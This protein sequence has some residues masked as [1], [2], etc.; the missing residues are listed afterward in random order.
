MDRRVK[1]AKHVR[2]QRGRK[3][4]CPRHRA[5]SGSGRQIGSCHPE[6][7]CCSHPWGCSH[8]EAA[9]YGHQCWSKFSGIRYKRLVPVL[10]FAIL[11]EAART[12]V[13]E[14][15]A[16]FLVV[17]ACEGKMHANQ[18]YRCNGCMYSELTGNAQRYRKHLLMVVAKTECFS[19]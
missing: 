10:V 7:S 6:R 18:P 17:S 2:G 1:K 15:T 5:Q 11:V 8:E 14:S 13:P 4:A 3:C 19:S 12:V 9:Q 16:N